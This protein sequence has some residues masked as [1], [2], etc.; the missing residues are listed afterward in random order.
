MYESVRVSSSLVRDPPLA[1]PPSPPDASTL[2]QALVGGVIA[3]VAIASLWFFYSRGL[4]N[5]Y[6]DAIAHMEGA[7]RLTDS[8]T[9]GYQEIG[10]VW[11][12]LFH[13]LV[14]PLAVNDTLWRTGLGGSLVS[15]AAFATTAWL[16]FR[17]GLEMNRNLAA[18]VVAAGGFVLAANMLY[19]AVTPLTEPLTMLWATST[20]YG[21]FRFYQSGRR[22]AFIGAA[23]AAFLG[24]LTRY[25]GWFLLPFAALFVMLAAK[26]DWML[27]LRK[28]V[29]F[30][31][32]AGLGPLLWLL[33]NA[34]R[35]GNPLEFYDGPYSAQ[36]IY[37]H[38]L[39]TTGFRYPTDGGWLLSLRYYLEDMKLVIGVWPLELA[40]LGL[41][42]WAVDGEGRSRR[43]AALLL[44]VPLPFYV[45]AMANA[46]V[47]IY[48]PTL[49]P[50]T[51][52]N[53][54]Y[55][56]EMLPAVALFPSFLVGPRL[57]RPAR[58][59]AL[60]LLL[61]AILLPCISSF[62][63]GAREL[64]TV[65]ESL[66]NTP[67]KAETDRSLI[68][69]FRER[70]DG[71]TILLGLGKYPCVLP[72]LGIPYRHTLTEANRKYWRE[73]PLGPDRWPPGSPLTSLHWIL[74]GQG[75]PVDEVMRAYPSAFASFE[76]V[77]QYAYPGEDRVQVYRL[78][79]AQGK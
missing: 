26:G 1:E 19:V 25:D 23:F 32:I 51:Y 53:L 46:A 35:F 36:A 64:V 20:A 13:L 62:S 7:R 74:R 17:L 2:A 73:L 21:L 22:T 34:H 78:H 24:T 71:G 31:A 15:M 63:V 79:S 8:L 60:I 67:C 40:L 50:H 45:Q 11:L 10:S 55:G 69:F 65:K 6:G 75:D 38:Q 30:S 76:L 27:R 14:A 70:Y 52:Y 37:A 39:A 48:V 59:A 54:R 49:F 68:D 9:P 18:G 56:L 12:P 72:T 41:V 3:L 42:V 47:P 61:G 66:L 5:L 16:L 57:T 44:L 33:H 4:T 28:A 29:I 58:D 43:A 77:A